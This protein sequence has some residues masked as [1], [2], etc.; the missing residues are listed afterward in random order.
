MTEMLP[1]LLGTL[2][3]CAVGVF[4]MCVMTVARSDNDEDRTP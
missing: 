3:G 1:F 2:V 4:L